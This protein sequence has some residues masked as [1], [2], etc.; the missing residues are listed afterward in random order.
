MMIS[1]FRLVSYGVILGLLISCNTT[2]KNKKLYDFS[3]MEKTIRSLDEDLSV[4]SEEINFLSDH[5][6]FLLENKDS[7]LRTADYNKYELEG[8]F[9]SSFPPSDSTLSTVA[10]M[11]T[12]QERSL[13]LSQLYL[14]NGMDSVFRK[15]YSKYPVIGQVY[16]NTSAQM[17][18][19][20][21]AYNA[22]M[23][24]D[25][26]LDL[27]QF[28]FYYKADLEHNPNKEAV[29]IKEVYIDPAGRGWILSLVKPVYFDDQLYAVLGI[30]ITVEKL[31]SAYL[32]DQSGNLLFANYQG[33]IVG[34]KSEAIELLSFPPLLNHVYHETIIS[35]NF[36]ISDFNLFN[37]K[38]REV[39]QMANKFI[40]EG[41]DF[42]QFEDQ[43]SPSS[44]SAVHTDLLN[45]Y[46]IEIIDRL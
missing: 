36:R 30:D 10:I 11:N 24:V 3:S 31:I 8:G 32:K 40:L 7:L 6:L 14:T 22:P 1:V 27:T 34:G 19:V 41:E 45:W 33:Y 15:T 2:E 43:F 16:L 29:W 4:L 42:F 5:F 17:S 39:R 20:Y 35:D 46:L 23:L 28:N 37:S 26:N 38:N 18:R 44:A 9:S 21:P 13:A 25:P 12:T